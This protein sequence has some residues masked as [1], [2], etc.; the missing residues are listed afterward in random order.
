[1]ACGLR[2]GHRS[3]SDYPSACR[4]KG[5]L[6]ST[7]RNKP[8]LSRKKRHPFFWVRRRRGRKYKS[9]N[10]QKTEGFYQAVQSCAEQY[11]EQ[12]NRREEEDYSEKA[13]EGEACACL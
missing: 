6:E 3:R 7:I 1:M 10:R 9:G 4:G 12:E 11:S 5:T 13:S 2:G 8:C